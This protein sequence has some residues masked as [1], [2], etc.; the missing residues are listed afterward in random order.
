MGRSSTIKMA[1]KNK[2]KDP[3][4]FVHQNEIL[5]ETI[6]KENKTAKI[7]T[8]Y[9]INPFKKMYILAGKPNSKHDTA[10]GEEDSHF[11]KVIERAN[12]EPVKKYAFPQTEAQEYGWISSPLIEHDRSDKRLSFQREMS[13]IT[14]YMDAAWRMKEQQQNMN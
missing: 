10:E 14:K 4:N 13:S 12:Q 3:V 5:V 8:N 7:F 11:L 2:E 9:G 1:D 6:K